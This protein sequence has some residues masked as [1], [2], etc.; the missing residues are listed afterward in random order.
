MKNKKALIQVGGGAADTVP[1]VLAV[2][3]E[4]TGSADPALSYASSLKAQ[5]KS[6]TSADWEVKNFGEPT[7]GAVSSTAPNTFWYTQKHNT[8][9]LLPDV[10]WAVMLFGHNDATKANWNEAQFKKDYTDLCKQYKDE[11][12]TR[13]V[14]VVIPPPM[15]KDEKN[16]IR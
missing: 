3:D 14:F 6:I 4:F 10:E 13:G 2:G 12:A 9:L 7:N 15:Y 5:L 11:V 1:T 16:G 8:S